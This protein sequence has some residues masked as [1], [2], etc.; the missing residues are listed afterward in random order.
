[1]GQVMAAIDA[2]GRFVVPKEMRVSLGVEGG[3][4][5]LLS[6]ENGALVAMTRAE[7]LRRARAMLTPWQPGEPMASEELIAERRAAARR[8]ADSD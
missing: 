3:G 1:M 6:L 2:S 5:L 4:E 7:A 8:D